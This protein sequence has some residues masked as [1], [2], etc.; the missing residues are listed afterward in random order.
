MQS[1]KN[2]K[3]TLNTN[4][5][6]EFPPRSTLNRFF[7]LRFVSGANSSANS[8]IA[9]FKKLFIEFTFDSTNSWEAL[10]GKCCVELNNGGSSANLFVCISS[11]LNS[12]TTDNRNA[13]VGKS[14]KS[15]VVF[16]NNFQLT[17]TCL[18]CTLYLSLLMEHPINRLVQF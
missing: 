7:Q 15:D 6:P 2:H 14:K 11:G 9:V 13:A 4:R 10:I 18:Q 5:S 3:Y 8:C 1:V 12:S 16:R 17:C